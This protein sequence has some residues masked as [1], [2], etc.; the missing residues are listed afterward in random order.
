MIV[1]GG[2]YC[3]QVRYKAEG[4]PMM[5][6]QCHCRECQ[7]IS[8]GET[9][10]FLA[11]PLAGFAYTKGTPKDV[12]AH[13]S[14]TAGD[15]RILCQLRHASGLATAGLS[16]RHHQGRH[17]RRSEGL[18]RSQHGDLYDRQAEFPSHSGRHAGVR[19]AAG[20]ACGVWRSAT[21]LWRNCASSDKPFRTA[22]FRAARFSRICRPPARPRCAC[23]LRRLQESRCSESRF[24]RERHGPPQR[25]PRPHKAA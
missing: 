12:L 9:N 6:G 14:R 23:D 19:A 21:E 10:V 8:G 3:G 17:A 2:C 4:E 7:Y 15:A 16:R 1:E 25:S 20:V 5:K 18:R 13:G 22:M 11:M 24:S